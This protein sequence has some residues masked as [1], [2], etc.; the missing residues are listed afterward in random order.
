MRRLLLTAAIAVVVAG[1]AI[2]PANAQ[3][4]N[5]WPGVAPGSERWTHKER[6]LDDTPIGPIVQNSSRRRSRRSCPSRA[7]PPSR[8]H[9]L[10][11]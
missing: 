6:A 1:L 4:I 2:E 8:A 5:V 3:T 11:T 10:T 9:E 7:R